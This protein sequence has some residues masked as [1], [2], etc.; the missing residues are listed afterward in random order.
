MSEN[1]STPY[2]K[3]MVLPKKYTH[4]HIKETTRDYGSRENIT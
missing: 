3:K 1:N 4:V 2:E